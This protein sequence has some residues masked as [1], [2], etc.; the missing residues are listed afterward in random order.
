MRFFPWFLLFASV[1]L[2][3]GCVQHLDPRPHGAKN[4]VPWSDDVV[5]YHL[6]PGD[7]IGLRFIL[8]PELNE[9]NIPIAPD[10]SLSA[11]LVGTVQAAG[12]TVEDLRKILTERYTAYLREPSPD[13]LIHAYD[14]A[15]VF[16]GGEVKKQGIYP[17]V[18]PTNAMQ[19]VIT[20][21]GAIDAA[22]MSETILI[23]RRADGRP[24]M[25]V[26]NLRR[27]LNTADS[28][29]NVALR[30][31]DVV[32]IPKTEA[33]SFDLFIEQYID[34]AIPFNRT[35]NYNVGTGMFY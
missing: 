23:R 33:G 22:E 31:G 3:G 8:N 26:V 32:Y 7:S 5:P 18:G 17:M 24:M 15:Q 19:A 34:K 21:G 25:R 27:Y 14:A 28:R 1:V 6:A 20:A 16:V 10:G 30:P 12:I 35:L 11:P 29:D 4:F 9:T 2:L 13:V